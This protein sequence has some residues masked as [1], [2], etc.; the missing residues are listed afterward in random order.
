MVLFNGSNM[1]DVLKLLLLA[2]CGGMDGC[3]LDGWMNCEG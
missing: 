1:I 3:M 2:S